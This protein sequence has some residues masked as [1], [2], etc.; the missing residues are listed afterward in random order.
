MGQS[1]LIYKE[2]RAEI[3]GFSVIGEGLAVLD[4]GPQLKRIVCDFWGKK[5]GLTDIWV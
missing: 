4:N 2:E 3:K 5:F 1:T